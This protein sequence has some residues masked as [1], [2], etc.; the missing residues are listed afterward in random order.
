MFVGESRGKRTMRMSV[1]SGIEGNEKIIQIEFFAQPDKQ[2]KRLRPN[3]YGWFR[4]RLEVHRTTM[5]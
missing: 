4:G 5:A 1:R 3:R 2:A